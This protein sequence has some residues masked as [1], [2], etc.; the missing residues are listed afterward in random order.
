MQTT[1]MSHKHAHTL[2][3]IFQHPTVHNLEWHDVVALMKH[4]G[5]VEQENNGNLLVTLNGVSQVLHHSQ[6]KEISDVQQVL[7]LRHFLESAGHGKSKATEAIAGS[8]PLRLLV[9]IN[10]Q[11][12]LVF[13]SED[14]DSVPERLHPYDP[15]G[16][17]SRLRHTEGV[18]RA[19]HAPENLAYYEQIA[20]TLAGANEVLLMGNGTG[21][22]RAMTHLEDYLTT[23]HPEIASKILGT[24]ALDLEALTEGQLLQEARTFF[25]E[26]GLAVTS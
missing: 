16:T 23:H 5:T 19:S 13:R 26:F 17:L 7:A 2:H 4:L 8:S 1:P 15:H 11:E 9:V 24:L 12:T 10:R 6:G 14:R 20:A 3:Q 18:D 22:S 21:A 25:Q